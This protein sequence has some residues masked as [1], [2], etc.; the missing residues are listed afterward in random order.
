VATGYDAGNGQT[1]ISNTI[2]IGYNTSCNARDTACIGNADISCVYLGSINGNAKLDCSGIVSSGL[3]ETTD[4]SCSSIYATKIG[5]ISDDLDLEASNL[6][7]LTTGTALISGNHGVTIEAMNLNGVDIVSATSVKLSDGSGAYINMSDGNIDISGTW[8]NGGAS[9]VKVKSM[10]AVNVIGQQVTSLS[11]TFDI[12]ANSLITKVTIVVFSELSCDVSGGAT[13]SGSGT[14]RF[15]AGKSPSLV[16]LII[17]QEIKGVGDPWAA[18]GGASSDSTL[19]F[20]PT[21]PNVGPFALLPSPDLFADWTLI[22]TIGD[23]GGAGWAAN[24]FIVGTMK[25]VV[26]YITF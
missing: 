10:T 11:G 17:D 22:M 4:I 15:K 16:D 20:K 2:N 6:N 25:F 14:I 9:N 21:L 7:V 1:D 23:T 13:G 26:E 24:N 18:K 8:A 3:V 5:T 19:A 12:P